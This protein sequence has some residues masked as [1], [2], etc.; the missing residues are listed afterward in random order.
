MNDDEL[1][2]T[3]RDV[4][5]ADGAAPDRAADAAESAFRWAG[6]EQELAEV[7]IDSA[8]A[9][10]LAGLRGPAPR[11]LT[12]RYADLVI[13]CELAADLLLAQVDPPAVIGLDLCSPDGDARPLAVDAAGR[14]Q[15]RPPAGPFSL[16]ARRAGQPDVLTPWLVAS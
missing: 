6:A 1:I 13:E 16:R 11:Q 12:W 4:L 7:V 15:A 2:A 8:D 3:L 9:P 10:A 5:G 14:C